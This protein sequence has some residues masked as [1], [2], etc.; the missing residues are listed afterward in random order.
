MQPCQR[1]RIAPIRLHS[2]TGLARHQA[3]HHHRALVDRMLQ[4][5]DTRRNRTGLPRSK[6]SATPHPDSTAR[7]AASATGAYCESFPGT[8]DPPGPAP[9]S[10]PRWCPCERPTQRNR[11]PL[12]TKIPSALL[13][14]DHRF[15]PQFAQTASSKQPRTWRDSG[16]EMSISDAVS[17]GADEIRAINQALAPPARARRRRIVAREAGRCGDSPAL[18]KLAFRRCAPIP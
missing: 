8:P 13:G 3:R 16:P 17:A 7:S 6:S 4:P 18:A 10:P 15:F 2:I 1:H 14:Y 9:R 11:Y 5:P 12:T